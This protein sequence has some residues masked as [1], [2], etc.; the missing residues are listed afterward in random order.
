MTATALQ[1]EG[2][3]LQP[4]VRGEDA[5]ARGRLD[6]GAATASRDRL[7]ACR[8]RRAGRGRRSSCRRRRRTRRSSC[9]A[10]W[11]ARWR[12]RV[13]GISWSPPDADHDDLLIKADKNPNTRGLVLQGVPLDGAARRAAGRRGR[14]SVQALV[15]CRTDLTAW[16]DAGAVRARARARAVPG[17]ARHRSARDGGVR[18]R[19]AA[20][21]APTPRPTAR[22][23]TTPVACSA[24]GAPSRRRAR[25]APGGACWPSCSRGCPASRPLASAEAVFAALAAEGR[26]FRGPQRPA[27][28]RSGRARGRS[29]LSGSPSRSAYQSGEAAPRP[30]PTEPAG[31]RRAVAAEHASG[32]RAR[33]TVEHRTVVM[34]EE[35]QHPGNADRPE[36]GHAVQHPRRSGG[37]E[38][39]DRLEI[40][41]SRGLLSCQPAH[42]GGARAE[43]GALP[44]PAT[45]DARQRRRRR[46]TPAA[47]A[48]QGSAGRAW[49]GAPDRGRRPPGA[50]CHTR[51]RSRRPR[52]PRCRAGRAPDRGE[53]RG[54][55][56]HRRRRRAGTAAGSKSRPSARRTRA[57]SG[58]STSISRASAP[59]TSS[60]HAPA[61]GPDD[62]EVHRAVR[63]LL[64]PLEDRLAAVAPAKRRERLGSAG[65][66]RGAEIEP[67]ACRKHDLRTLDRHA[68]HP[69][70][71]R[72]ANASR[73]RQSDRVS[74]A[75]I[76]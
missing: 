32:E 58:A 69:A 68:E 38:A 66:H 57:A 59:V 22:S 51:A 47:P 72:G 50:R 24:S 29:V 44:E 48:G 27:A 52:T 42:P 25:R 6:G 20:R 9:C 41:T 45:V 19:R 13:A 4:L 36:S 34:A 5:F 28:R 70:L 37:G 76:A 73:P 16:R 63:E 62:E 15:L 3:L 39:V 40:A 74:R 55:A 8:G 71:A 18:Q 64:R 14:G 46:E 56:A 12:R 33:R 53:R 31:E 30:M 60:T 65:E 43:S 10:G 23:R 54:A 21:S 49:R 67:A 26:A 11:R 75:G 1:G 35:E 7:R 61:S 17:G 2:R